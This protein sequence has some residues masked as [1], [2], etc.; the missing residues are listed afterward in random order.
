LLHSLQ[1][2]S[3]RYDMLALL[4]EDERGCLFDLCRDHRR[5]AYKLDAMGLCPSCRTQLDT[6][7]IDSA[8]VDAASAIVASLQ[9]EACPA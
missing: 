3:P 6:C 9:R 7:G 4:H 1:L 2:V 8:A 5:L